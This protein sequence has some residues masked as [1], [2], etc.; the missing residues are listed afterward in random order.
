[1]RNL[2]IGLLILLGVIIGLVLTGEHVD[3]FITG[4]VSFSCHPGFE[5]VNCG[6]EVYRYAEDGCGRGEVVVCTNY[7][8]LE[9]ALTGLDL[10]CPEYCGDF[11]VPEEL[12]E[13]LNR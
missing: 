1:M 4:G 7:C 2:L 12:V 9:R 5:G 6:D 13:R 8:I 11:C 3:D 10:I